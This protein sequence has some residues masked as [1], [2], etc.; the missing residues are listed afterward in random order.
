MTASS[1]RTARHSS[2]QLRQPRAFDP[3]RLPDGHR[4][5]VSAY[6]GRHT[7]DLL[8][9]KERL[10]RES[11]QALIATLRQGTP[12]GRETA[13]SLHALF[14]SSSFT[15]CDHKFPNA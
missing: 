4:A 8:K 1:R 3:P 12:L 13:E 14:F 6:F 9:L 2:P 5:P 11:Y 10:P 15:F 7:L